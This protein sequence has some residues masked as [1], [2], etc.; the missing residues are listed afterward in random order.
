MRFQLPRGLPGRLF[1]AHA[2][3][4]LVGA[5]TIGLIVAVVGPA[6][7]RDH[8]RQIPGPVDAATAH[9]VEEAY[10]FAS[11]LSLGVALVAS[12]VA[13]LAVSAYVSRR[14]A[15]PVEQLAAAA[16]DVSRGHYGARVNVTGLGAEFDTVAAAFNAM[17]ERLADV[18]ATR[19]RLLAD[20]GHELRTPVATIEAYVDAAE[21][22]VAVE[23]EDTWAV[24]RAQTGRLRRLTEDLVAV[25]RAEE[26]QL[27][28]RPR[29]VPVAELVSAAVAAARPRYAAKGVTLREVV[30]LDA[31]EVDAD[32]ERMAQV[33]GNLLDNALRHTPPGGQVS[34]TTARHRT[35]VRVSVV[36]TGDGI[37]A[38][39]LPHVF[40]RFY[41]S[42]TARD[43]DHGGTGI[44]LAVAR[45]IVRQHGGEAEATSEGPGAGAEFTVT[46]PAAGTHLP[47]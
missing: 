20:L 8:F 36:D 39:H 26:H 44:G 22:G 13:A 11:A 38:A 47:G 1:A 30:E 9:H 42:D 7:F 43:R 29:R 24:L 21:D 15:H 4:V 6:I 10:T 5:S 16:T 41:R 19:R 14:L 25:S 46:L 40:E 32:I 3:V 35:G 12:L 17:A 2:L 28:L 33:L 31:G 27:D 34:V 37:E 23:G 45:A 18:E